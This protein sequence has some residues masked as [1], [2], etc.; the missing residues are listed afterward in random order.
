MVQV[1]PIFTFFQNRILFPQLS[2]SLPKCTLLNP[3][4]TLVSTSQ[5]YYIT[6]HI[7]PFI[8]S[9]GCVLH[10]KTNFISLSRQTT[11]ILDNFHIMIFTRT[12]LYHYF[13]LILTKQNI[14]T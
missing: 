6:Y 13:L 9:L 2:F 4:F 5:L 1:D 10:Y 3:V 14:I 7:F 12:Y 11:I 8:K